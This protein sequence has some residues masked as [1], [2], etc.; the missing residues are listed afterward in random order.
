MKKGPGVVD[1]EA[2]L[3]ERSNMVY[4]NT[5]AVRGR[6]KAVVVETGMDTEVGEIATEIQEAEKGQTPFQ[7]EVN[8]LGKKISYGIILI[9]L[10]VAA[11]E[12]FLTTAPPVTIFLVAVS[13]AV[14]AVPE[15]LPAVVTLTLAMGSKKMVKKNALVR[16][17]PVVESLGSVDM[18]VTDKTGTLTENTMTVRRVY[19]DGEVYEV[20]GSG[21]STEGKFRREG[22]EIRSEKLR[23]VL[24]PGLYCN[25]AE[26]APEEEE[27]DYYG[28]PTEVALLVSAEKAGIEVEGERVREVPFSSE[29]KRMTTVHEREDGAVAYMKGAP[30][31][32]LE[33]CDRVLENGEEVELTEERREEILGKNRDFAG[34]ALRVLGFARKEVEDAEEEAREIE[35]GMVFT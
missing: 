18:I 34:D 3:A 14:A 16:R 15:G 24:E 21:T 19:F 31:T 2:S 20:T 11:S 13:L 5:N 29:R 12:Y 6:G 35:S 28:D 8:E 25:N 23:P 26:E 10:L 1:E 33:R 4:M 22:E 17:L 30:E 7:E 9:I 27:E 32:V